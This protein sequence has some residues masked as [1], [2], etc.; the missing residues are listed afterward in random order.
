MD[1]I[2]VT[3]NRSHWQGYCEHN[4]ELL[5]FVRGMEF[6][7]KLNDCCFQEECSSWIKLIL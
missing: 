3:N 7:D 2:H 6:L 4:N 1:L 5:Y